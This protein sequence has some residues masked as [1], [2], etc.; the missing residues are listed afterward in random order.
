MI[1][2]IKEIKEDKKKIKEDILEFKKLV[3][4]IDNLLKE[5]IR[6]RD[7]I[8]SNYPNHYNPQDSWVDSLIELIEKL[9]GDNNEI[10]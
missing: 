3:I 9:E 1:R 10:N 5:F 8:K 2:K 6:M 4:N 7:Y